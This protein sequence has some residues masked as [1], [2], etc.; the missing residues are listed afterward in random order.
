MVG[1][2]LGSVGF[3]LVVVNGLLVVDS[4]Q[5]ANSNLELSN[6]QRVVACW[7]RVDDRGQGIG[8]RKQ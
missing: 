1:S 2:E 6:L 7:Y 5:G 4:V 8:G 3:V